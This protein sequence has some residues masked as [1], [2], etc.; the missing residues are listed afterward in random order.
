MTEIDATALRESCRTL[1]S[2]LSEALR[3]S[4]IASHRTTPQWVRAC[5]TA[6]AEAEA[7]LGKRPT[8]P[9]WSQKE[10]PPEDWGR[11]PL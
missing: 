1:A 3:K 10:R 4:F 7:L 9:V 6:V 5:Q 11:S 8:R 2:L